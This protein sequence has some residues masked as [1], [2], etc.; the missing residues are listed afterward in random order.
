MTSVIDFLLG[1][2]SLKLVTFSRTWREINRKPLKITSIVVTAWP[3]WRFLDI[4]MSH[5][6]PLYVKSKFVAQLECPIGCFSISSRCVFLVPTWSSLRGIAWCPFLSSTLILDFSLLS[7]PRSVNL[8]KHLEVS[9]ISFS[10]F[11]CK[12]RVASD[13]SNSWPC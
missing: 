13:A 11:I 6:A 3:K 10:S 5:F 12:S 2:G 9:R 8:W 7:R 4:I 1:S